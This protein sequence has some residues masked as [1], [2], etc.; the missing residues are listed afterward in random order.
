L[1]SPKMQVLLA[2]LRDRYDVVI[3]D[4]PPVNPVIDAAAIGA[5]L[6]GVVLVAEWGKTPMDVLTGAAG[7][8]FTAQANVLGVALNKVDKSLATVRWQKDWGYGYYRKAAAPMP[9]PAP[10]A[11][12]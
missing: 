6:D 1:T 2:A 4:L 3:A 7:V 9:S 10:G 12:D 5:L 8:L 11:G